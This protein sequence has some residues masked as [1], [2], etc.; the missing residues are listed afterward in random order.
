MG[1]IIE[2][3]RANGTV[4]Y[5]AKIAIMRDGRVVFRQSQTFD[6]RPAATAWI[7]KREREL[8]KPG[9]IEAAGKTAGRLSDAIDRYIVTS[10][11]QMGDTKAQ[12]LRSLKE[13]PIASKP[14]GDIRSQDIVALAQDL[15]QSRQPQTVANY[16]SHLQAV[17]AIARPAWGFD[18]DSGAMADAVKVTRRLGLTSKSRQRDRRPT[19][20]ELDLL[21]SYFETVRLKRP[22]SSPMVAVILFALF[23]TRR[24]DEIARITWSDFDETGKRVLVRDMKNPGEKIGNDVWC[25]LPAEAMAVI[26]LM[27][28]SSGTIFPISSGSVSAAFTRACSFLGIADLHF[29]DL[30]HDGVSRLFELGW[31]IPHVAAVSGHRSW[32]SLKRYT[33][34]RQTG[35]KYEGWKWLPTNRAIHP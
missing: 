34:L 6:R 19:I 24:Q 18:L 28:R 11:K 23:S 30:R 33:H 5:L 26:A 29:H 1:S 35:D 13:H 21:L 9:G 25:D 27:P 32:Q 7:E 17:F 16:L 15:I 4:A 22:S 3:P 14:C 8:S 20:A 10:R 2:R 12:V 31:N